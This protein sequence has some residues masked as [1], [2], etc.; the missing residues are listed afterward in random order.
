MWAGLYRSLIHVFHITNI[1]MDQASRKFHAQI[2]YTQIDN[3]R[4]MYSHHTLVHLRN[5]F[6]MDSW[7]WMHLPCS[8][9]PP[10]SSSHLQL[11]TLVEDPFQNLLQQFSNLTWHSLPCSRPLCI[12]QHYNYKPTS[13]VE[14]AQTLSRQVMSGPQRISSHDEHGNCVAF[15]QPL[16]L[17]YMVPKRSSEWRP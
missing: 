1:E 15:L 14:C 4:L 16:V 12:S 6:L 17:T 8:T 5:K 9:D 2:L 3:P 7:H 13:V 10:S 11:V